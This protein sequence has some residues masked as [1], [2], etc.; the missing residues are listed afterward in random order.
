[1]VAIGVN[2]AQTTFVNIE[3]AAVYEIR[4]YGNNLPLYRNGLRISNGGHLGNASNLLGLVIDA[5]GRL[6]MLT[7]TPLQVRHVT[8]WNTNIRFSFVQTT[9]AP[10]V[11]PNPN[12][13][14]LTQSLYSLEEIE[15]AIT[16]I[17][18]Y[19]EYVLIRL[20]LISH[21]HFPHLTAEEFEALAAAIKAALTLEDIIVDASTA[22]GLLAALSVPAIRR[23]RPPAQH[24]AA[25]VELTNAE[26]RLPVTNAQSRISLSHGGETWYSTGTSG[27]GRYIFY[28]PNTPR[29]YQI[30]ITAEGFEPLERTVFVGADNTNLRFELVPVE[31]EIV[32]LDYFCAELNIRMYVTES[33]VAE[34]GEFRDVYVGISRFMDFDGGRIGFMYISNGSAWEYIGEVDFE[35]S[36]IQPFGASIEPF[37]LPTIGLPVSALIHSTIFSSVGLGSILA[38]FRRQP[39]QEFMLGS[40]HQRHQKLFIIPEGTHWSSFYD[41]VSDTLL[42][43]TESRVSQFGRYRSVYVGISR[44]RN[45]RYGRVY[46][47]GTLD[48]SP[49]ITG[50]MGTWDFATHIEFN[51]RYLARYRMPNE[52]SNPLAIINMLG[53]N[54]PLGGLLWHTLGEFILDNIELY[55]YDVIE[56]LFATVLANMAGFSTAQTIRI[57]E[58]LVFFGILRH[59]IGFDARHQANLTLFPEPVGFI[60][61]QRNTPQA[62]LNIGT[63]GTG[64]DNGCG[65][66]AIHNALFALSE[67]GFNVAPPCIAEII[68]DINMAGGFISGGQLGTNPLVMQSV[69]RN[70]L[71]NSGLNTLIHFEPVNLNTRIRSSHASVLLYSW[72]DLNTGNSGIHYVM[73]HYVE[74]EFRMF[75]EFGRDENFEIYTSI[76]L[77]I[78]GGRN[79]NQSRNYQPVALITISG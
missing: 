21:E 35:W 25:T 78:Q 45:S 48:S 64:G 23:T 65:P 20:P 69:L 32:W 53:T 52:Q 55:E 34:F 72:T 58:Q 43:M 51:S 12:F 1:M 75:N 10:P 3:T 6:T 33:R 66:I 71:R 2:Y 63:R 54:I 44:Q 31:Q 40:F 36:A 79:Q 24:W 16:A 4:P 28:V 18:G 15:A 39:P 68:W 41:E 37:G 74:N 57:F 14:L 19:G 13:P 60:H 77:W 42:F 8:S 9:P 7:H 26:T 76:D 38:P 11:T 47:S 61:G 67:R 70:H 49:Y 73:I 27:A 22:A 29:Q 17:A 62:N 30:L 46:V 59:R 5:N 56:S 50:G